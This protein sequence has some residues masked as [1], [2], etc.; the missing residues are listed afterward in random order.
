MNIG[1]C[2]GPAR[3]MDIIG[4]NFNSVKN[5]V[6]YLNQKWLSIGLDFWPFENWEG[7]ELLKVVGY[8]VYA[9]WDLP[10]GRPFISHISYFID[11]KNIRNF[12]RLDIAAL[13]ACDIWLYLWKRNQGLPFKYILGKLPRQKDEWF[14]DA[15]EK[16]YGGLCCTSYFKISHKR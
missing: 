7:H 4:I 2:E 9:A 15:S 11:V 3:S 14:V 10:F 5:H 13:T 1:K 12:V 6:F 16:G 8:L